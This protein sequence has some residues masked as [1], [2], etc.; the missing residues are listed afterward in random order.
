VWDYILKWT[1]DQ[2]IREAREV[3]TALPRSPR[4]RRQH[5]RTPGATRRALLES[6]TRLFSERG[7][8]AVSV[9]DLARRA[10]VNKALVSYHFGGKQGLYLAVLERGFADM[11]DRLRVVE[12]APDAREGL[13]RFFDAFEDATRERSDF[14]ALFV[15][16]AV[17]RGIEPAVVPHLLQI[18]GITRLGL[19]ASSSP[20]SPLA[21]ARPPTFPSGCPLPTP[22]SV[23][24]GR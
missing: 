12:E 14:P 4:R 18:M 22:S 17:S 2:K 9:E 24:S 3:H 13:R 23:T 11:A 8:D 20:P 1:F 7:Y 6:G 19:W 10:R 21:I 15:R 5:R 16:E